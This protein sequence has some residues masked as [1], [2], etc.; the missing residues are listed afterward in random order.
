M[1]R[2]FAGMLGMFILL[3][4]V[5]WGM[6]YLTSGIFPAFRWLMEF[7]RWA[8]RTGWTALGDLLR[9][10][11]HGIGGLAGKGGKKKK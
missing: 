2:Q 6:E 1:D 10:A 8:W 11:C 4:F 7:E 3:H 9:A 5:C